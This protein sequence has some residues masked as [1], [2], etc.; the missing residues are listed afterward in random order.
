MQ[1]EYTNDIGH[2]EFLEGM[3][4]LAA[5][6]SLITTLDERDAPAGMLATAVTS[7]SS[8]P[9]TLLVCV[10][11]EA[12]MHADL[13]RSGV[14]CV[15]V[16]SQSNAAIAKLF[17]S[18]KNRERRFLSG[19]WQRLTTGAPALEDSLVAFDCRFEQTVRAGTHTVIFGRVL[20]VLKRPTSGGPLIYFDRGYL[21]I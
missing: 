12:T 14:F 10:N 11:R 20:D 13:I 4:R 19:N 5:G 8:D 17:S 16:L 7:V 21:N 2:A 3:S 15:S 6:V 18:G 1:A 9:P